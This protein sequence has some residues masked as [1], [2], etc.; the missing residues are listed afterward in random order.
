MKNYLPALLLLLLFTPA[1]KKDGL[2]KE[3]QKGANTLSCKVDGKTF[4]ACYK[5]TI[6]GPDVPALG[7]GVSAIDN[8]WRATVFAENQC[9]ERR[10]GILI[11]ISDFT[12]VGE[13]SLAEPGNRA[14]YRDRGS[15]YY[16]SVHTKKG[17]IVITK[18]DRSKK[19]LSGTFEFSGE[20]RN[21]N[22]GKIV[23]ITS[24]RFDIS[25][26]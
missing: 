3:T 10:G 21:S 7:G 12:G 24:G 8:R 2:T 23:E 1:C 17:K 15:Y 19:I 11:E 9:D 16:Q 18:D 22:P 20:D 25:Y 5:L 13:Y 6:G 4:K 26:K 14:R